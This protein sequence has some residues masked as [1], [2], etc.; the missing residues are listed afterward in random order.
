MLPSALVK[1]F[2]VSRMR[3]FISGHWGSVNKLIWKLSNIDGILALNWWLILYNVLNHSSVACRAAQRYCSCSSVQDTKTSVQYRIPLHRL[4][5]STVNITKHVDQTSIGWN[6]LMSNEKV[7]EGSQGVERYPRVW[8]EL[9]VFSRNPGC[10]EKSQGVGRNLSIWK[11][12]FVRRKEKK[13]LT[14]DTESLNWCG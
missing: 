10:E 6:L 1:R 7:L 8:G 9:L 13:L 11:N 4:L 14:G 2:S 12:L 5:Y 3:D